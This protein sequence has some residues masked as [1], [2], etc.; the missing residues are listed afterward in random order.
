M[1]TINELKTYINSDEFQS[2]LDRFLKNQPI[3]DMLKK[4]NTIFESEDELQSYNILA[5]EFN[6]SA[7]GLDAIKEEIQSNAEAFFEYYKHFFLLYQDED[8]ANEIDEGDDWKPDFE[9]DN[10]EECETMISS[11]T[12]LACLIEFHLLKTDRERLFDYHKKLKIPNAKKH[13]K[14]LIE[15]YDSI[16]N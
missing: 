9:D 7:V 16:F 13:S 11:C 12:L 10:E 1:I 3:A 4:H 15:M 8:L 5:E 6:V 2:F 14:L